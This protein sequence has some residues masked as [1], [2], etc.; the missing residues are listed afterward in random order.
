MD[1]KD[2]FSSI[3]LEDL[4]NENDHKRE[5]VIAIKGVIDS[6]IIHGI[7]DERLESFF[8]IITGAEYLTINDHHLRQVIIEG[9]FKLLFSVKI[10]D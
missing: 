4:N 1:Y 7:E 10:F 5:K 9:V 3:L 8:K 2:I 6:L